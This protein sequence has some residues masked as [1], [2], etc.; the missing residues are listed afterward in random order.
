VDQPRTAHRLLTAFGLGAVLGTGLD[1]IHVYGDVEAY[2]HEV[3]GRLGWF[4]PIEFGLA[5]MASALAI[6][7]LER[8]AG[9]GAPPP[10]TLWERFR[11]VPLLAGLYV[12]SV[13]ANGENATLFAVGLLILVG[14]RLAFGGVRGDWAFALVAGI[15]G[16]AVEAA[17][18]ATGAFHYTEPD[19]LGIPVWLPALWANGGLAIRRLF[20]PLSVGLTASRPRATVHANQGGD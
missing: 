14:A 19:F 9:P 1:A 4:V 7:V 15:V 16:P 6:P 11:E 17:I 3:L 13:G 12:A 18:H 8:L 5:G 2:P 10:W 20:G